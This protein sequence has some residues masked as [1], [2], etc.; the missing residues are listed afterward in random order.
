MSVLRRRFVI[1][2]NVLVSALTEESALTEG[3]KYSTGWKYSWGAR[4]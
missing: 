4:F 3:K 1:D 2:T